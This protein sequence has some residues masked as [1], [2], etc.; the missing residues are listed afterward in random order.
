MIQSWAIKV[1][2]LR[3]DYP[4]LTAVHDLDFGVREG[5]IHGFLGPN[6]A[7]KSTT[8]RMICGLLRPTSGQVLVQ[9]FNPVTQPDEVKALVGLLPENTPLYREMSVEDFL[10]FAARL[11]NVPA[12]EVAKNVTK[13]IDQTGLG[14]VRSRLI[15]NLSK[16]YRQRVGI[17]QSLVHNPK[18]VILDEPTA[19]LDPQSVV[20]IRS[21]I[22]SLKG[23]KTIIFSSHI[24]SEVEEI[25][26]TISIIGRGHLKANGDLQD[27]KRAFQG[28]GLVKVETDRL[29]TEA[30]LKN[31]LALNFVEAVEVDGA[32]LKI[33][34]RSAQDVRPELVKHLVGIGVGVRAVEY[35]VPQLEQVFMAVTKQEGVV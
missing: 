26:D 15:G 24:L 11:R 7:G 20:E 34:P 35:V 14:D 25:C 17:A 28:K 33:A 29:L 6:G 10:V 31:L 1:E 2:K 8:L 13:V 18:V 3:K 30:E 16:G 9:T 21:L 19:G 5:C 4:G 32:W 23:E 22:K 12:T 27:I